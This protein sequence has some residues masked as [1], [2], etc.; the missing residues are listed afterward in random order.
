MMVQ[1][2]DTDLKLAVKKHPILCGKSFPQLLS[3]STKVSGS[4]PAVSVVLSTVNA[5]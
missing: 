4:S 2:I 1:M 3:L 5:I